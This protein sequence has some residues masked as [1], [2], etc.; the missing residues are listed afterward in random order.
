MTDDKVSR[1]R[2]F[3]FSNKMKITEYPFKAVVAVENYNARLSSIYN[4]TSTLFDVHIQPYLIIG[5]IRKFC[6]KQVFRSN[7]NTRHITYVVYKFVIF[8]VKSVY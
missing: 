4:N 8:C 3:C 2:H 1:F 7:V 6:S 5:V